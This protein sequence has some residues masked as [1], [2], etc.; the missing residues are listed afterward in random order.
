MV[1]VVVVIV[2]LKIGPSLN[3]HAMYKR[4]VTTLLCRVL[5]HHHGPLSSAS[6][7]DQGQTAILERELLL[8]VVTDHSTDT[9]QSIEQRLS[10]AITFF[11]APSSL[12]S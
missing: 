5:V 11:L 10:Q 9:D 1:T 4:Q 8:K 6:P 3:A 12:P 2:A 7:H